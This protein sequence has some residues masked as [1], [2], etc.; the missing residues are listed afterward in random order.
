MKS[1]V[2]VALLLV[3]AAAPVAAQDRNVTVTVFASQVDMDEESDLEGGSV[4]EFEEGEALGAAANFF[5]TRLFSVEAAVFFIRTDAG[6][7]V[8]GAAPFDLGSLDLTPISLGVQLHPLGQSRFDPYIGAG[9]AYV[10]ADDLFSPD[11][12][13]VGFGRIELEDGLTYYANA[14]IGFQITPG[15]GIVVDGRWIPFETE[16]RSS[17]TGVEQDLDLSSR[18]LSAGVRLRF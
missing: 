7:L 11:L 8:E 12:D 2:I 9:G 16:S 4:T 18:V 5:V 15:F 10:L 14:G 13:L 3:F 6:L 17:V 1:A